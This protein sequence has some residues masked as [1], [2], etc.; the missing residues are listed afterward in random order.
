M[1]ATSGFASSKGHDEQLVA[2]QAI[3]VATNTRLSAR[4]DQSSIVGKSEKDVED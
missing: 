4:R 2:G 3:P 1:P